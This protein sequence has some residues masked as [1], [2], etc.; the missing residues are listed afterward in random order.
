MAFLGRV[1]RHAGVPGG[2]EDLH[3]SAAGE[4]LGVVAGADRS[5]Q[6]EITLEHQ[7]SSIH[8]SAPVA[9]QGL[10]S[11]VQQPPGAQKTHL[12]SAYMS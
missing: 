2:S 7:F 3:R 5:I 1:G 6:T 9:V 11:K 8:T 4:V 10:P 12:H